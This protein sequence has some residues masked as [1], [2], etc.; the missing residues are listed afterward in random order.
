MKYFCVCFICG[1]AEAECGHREP[2]LIS[3][4]RKVLERQA[5]GAPGAAETPAK[6]VAMPEPAKTAQQ[7]RRREIRRAATEFRQKRGWQ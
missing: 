2:E 4:S 7:R 1:S 5:Q 3:Y 6:V